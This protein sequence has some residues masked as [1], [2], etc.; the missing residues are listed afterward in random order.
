MSWLHPFK[1]Q[2]L[3]I[4]GSQK[5]AVFDD[6]QPENKLVLYSHR[7]DWFDRKPV[8]TK[9][10]SQVIPVPNREPLR[11]ECEHFLDCVLTRQTP[12]TDGESALRVLE[13]LEACGDSLSK[14]GVPVEVQKSC[15][16]YFAHGT[17][18]IDEPC[19]IGDRTK[20]WHF[21]HIMVGASLGWD[22]NLGQNVV[23]SPTYALG[24]MSKSKTMS[25]FIA[26]LNWRMTSFAGIQWCLP[27]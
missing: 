25:Q 17:A 24:T 27:M 7:I 20:I 9:N 14:K 2:K 19:Q 10:G 3:A 11:A 22:C 5:M 1:E 4:I 12:R 18:V 23:V 8:A 13:V 26:G 16:N 6:I 15:V 21:S